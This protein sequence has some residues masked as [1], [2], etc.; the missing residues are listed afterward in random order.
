MPS[1]TMSTLRPVGFVPFLKPE[2]SMNG[3]LD[4]KTGFNFFLGVIISLV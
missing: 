2:R 1:F 4:L 3:A